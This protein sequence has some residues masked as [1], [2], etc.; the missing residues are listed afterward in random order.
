[1]TKEGRENLLLAALAVSVAV[2]VALMFA[3]RTMVMTHVDRSSLKAHRKAP[4][5]A[6]RFVERPDPVSMDV[7]K[8]LIA[9]KDAPGAGEEAIPAAKPASDER[10]RSEEP[11]KANPASVK[12][13][14]TVIPKEVPAVFEVEPVGKG[15]DVIR[16]PEMKLETPTL[17]L[18]AAAPDV[19]VASGPAAETPAFAS[20]SVAPPAPA[21]ATPAAALPAREPQAAKERF[22]PREEV[23]EK[24]DEKLVEAEKTAVRDLLD[25]EKVGDI[26]SFVAIRTAM[27]PAGKWTYFRVDISPKGGFAPVPKDVVVLI[28]A[29]GSIGNDRLKSCR[30]AA[31]RILRSCTNTGDRFNLVAFRD[32]FKYAFRSWRECDRDSFERADRWLDSLAAH[33]RTDVFS[34]IRSVLALPRNPSRPLVALVVTDGDANEGVSETSEILSK[35]TALNDGLVSVYMYGVKG[36]ANRKLIDVLTRGNRGESFIFGGMRWNAG[37]GIEG[38]SERFRDP[39]LSDFRMVFPTA[40]RAEAYPRLLRNLCRGGTVEVFGRVPA[41]SKEV[42]FSLKGLRGGEA[43]EG[44]F[45]LPLSAATVDS[46]L[47]DAWEKERGIDALLR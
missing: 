29:S 8:D 13:P 30:M 24:V 11:V 17:R 37:S 28:D 5:Q 27:F 3:A 44:F 7:V 19:R 22:V 40:L 18:V 12:P 46:T 32:R 10:I 45:R 35:F 21:A 34:T 16:P 9:K 1:M 23:S 39:V 15:D 6:K 14:E 43:Y 42:S 4:M 2:H 20:P 26:S 38:L 41:G 31:K 36:A 25:A 33:G 47:P